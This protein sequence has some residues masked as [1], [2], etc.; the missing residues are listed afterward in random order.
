MRPY[1]KPHPQIWIPGVLSKSTV[2]WAAEHR[3]PYVMLDSQLE[4]TAQAFDYYREEAAKNGYEAGSQHLGYMF[5]VHVD[6]TEEKAYEMGRKFIEGAGNLFLDGAT[7]RGQPVGA[8][9]SR[10]S[11]PVRTGSPPPRRSTSRSRGGCSSPPITPLGALAPPI[12]EKE[13]EA[14]RKAIF[15]SLLENYSIIVGTP[16]SVLPKIRHVLE[17]VGA[18]NVIFWHGDGD[19]THED[20]MRGIRL[21]GEKV[22]PA[23]REMGKELGLNSSFEVSPYTNEPT[24]P[25]VAASA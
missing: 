9:P 18:G 3:Y 23:V 15:D 17:I 6:E 22:L 25:L 14:R 13:H 5:K 10:A 19:M 16:E 4:L 24:A 1:Q 2:A 12:S 8:E 11:T 20:T 7:G 21:L